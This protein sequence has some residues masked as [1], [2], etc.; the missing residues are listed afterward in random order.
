MESD[1]LFT[2]RFF[3][4]CGFSFTVFLSAFQLLPTA[5]YRVLAL[6]GSKF[7]AGLVLGCLTYASAIS[8]PFTGALSDRLGRRRTL[9]AVSLVLASFAFLYA[10]VDVVWLML[11]LVAVHGVFWSALLSASAA[12]VTE[13]M[14]ESRRAEG[15][16]Y[17]GLAS[18][19]SVALA[20]ALGLALFDRGW[21]WVCLS[22]G[23]LNLVMAAI[24]WYLPDDR[25][26]PEPGRKSLLGV[27]SRD[28][29]EWRVTLLAFTL[30]LY[31]FG[32]GG[33]TSFVALYAQSS[34]VARGLW[35]SAFSAAVLASRP[36]S[37]RLADRVGHVRVFLPCIALTSLGYALLAVGGS[38]QM[39]VVSA[40]V[41]GLGFGSS[42][43]VF[44][45]FVMAHTRSDRRGAA[46]GGILAALDTGI[47]SGSMAMGWTIEH[48]GFRPAYALGA[49]MA[50]LA[51]PY[52]L[53]VRP[54]FLRLTKTGRA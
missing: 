16:S 41:F 17:W 21:T 27:F 24:A 38:R 12:Y 37:G 23:A 1:R 35:F 36:F 33:V 9:L 32:Y 26:G 7:A 22:I 14:P 42:Y 2:P 48:Y 10:W 15:I 18:T 25:R 40:V 28:A 52:F 3:L 49:A 29:V 53:A 20:P 47:G 19:F 51:I 30:F 13:R 39:F 6:G 34:G 50:V 44:A 5:P 43:P 31:A 11:A 46:F 45:A 4:M 8:A 54:V